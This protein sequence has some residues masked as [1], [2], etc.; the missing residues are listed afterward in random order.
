MFGNPLAED[1]ITNK[2]FAFLA[3]TI[4]IMEHHSLSFVDCNLLMWLVTILGKG[5]NET[6]QIFYGPRE[7]NEIVGKEDGKK[8]KGAKHHMPS[9][10]VHFLEFVNNITKKYNKKQRTQNATFTRSL[11]E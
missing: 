4:S 9:F 1:T 10:K 11:R 2:T 7:L 6:L 8:E 5:I 3:A